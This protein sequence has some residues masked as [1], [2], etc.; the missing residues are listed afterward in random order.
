[1][2]DERDLLA[3]LV[4]GRGK[5]ILGEC[6]LVADG[7]VNVLGDLKTGKLTGD[8]EEGGVD[9]SSGVKV[10]G[11]VEEGYNDGSVPIK[12]DGSEV[13]DPHVCAAVVGVGMKAFGGRRAVGEGVRKYTSGG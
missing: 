5:L 11:D 13:V 1:M 6:R 8:G 7:G 3:V 12:D 4:D 9:E 10:V 2:S